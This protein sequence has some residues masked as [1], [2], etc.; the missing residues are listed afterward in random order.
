VNPPDQLLART[1]AGEPITGSS[2]GG[3]S[4]LL[5]IA[6]LLLALA[7]VGAVIGIRL[8]NNPDEQGPVEEATPG[9]DRE[10]W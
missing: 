5:L 10:V 1:V 2:S 4:P 8:G 3:G 9:I 7:G 6:I